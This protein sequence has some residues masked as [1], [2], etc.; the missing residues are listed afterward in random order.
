MRLDEL[1]RVN[2]D[3][4]NLL[5][6]TDIAT[7][8]L[9]RQLMIKSFTPAISEIFSLLPGDVGRPLADL[10][11]KIHCD[12]LIERMQTVQETLISSE[13]EVETESDS[14][15]QMRI[16]P[17]RSVDD[18]IEGVVA[19][20]SDIT[21]VRRAEQRAQWARLYA[22]SLVEAIPSPLVILGAH[23]EILSVN[24]AFQH[25]FGVAAEEAQGKQLWE[26]DSVP[27]RDS[28]LSEALHKMA[29]GEP[30]FDNLELEAEIPHLG[31]RHFALQG[32]GIERTRDGV[33]RVLVSL[34]DTTARIAAQEAT[35]RS[36]RLESLGLLAGGIAHDFNNLLMAITGNAG[37]A[38]Q[39]L[40]PDSPAT[41]YMR[42]IESAGDRAADLVT[43]M[44][45][46]AGQ[47]R[48]ELAV[49]DL[50]EVIEG[51]QSL[52]RSSLPSRA[53]VRYRLAADLPPVRADPGQ[54]GQICLNLLLNAKE[55]LPDEGGGIV[56]STG[57]VEADAQLFCSAY[58]QEDLSPGTYVFLEVADSGAG[59]AEATQAKMFDPFF[60][61]KF[62]GRG[63][64][65]A[66][67]LG[68]VRQHGGTLLVKSE[69]GSGTRVTMLLPETRGTLSSRRVD[70][71]ATTEMPP[72]ASG[73]GT[74][75]V[76]DDE[77]AVAKVT[78]SMLEG[79]G[80]GVETAGS[81]SSAETVLRDSEA[82]IDIVLLDLMMPDEDGV[83]TLE[84]LRRIR[85]DL[86][87]ILCSGFGREEVSRRLGDLPID[88]FLHKPYGLAAL[89]NT[90][91]GALR[92]R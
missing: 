8:F 7:I 66:A 53:R 38:R 28:G 76:V 22:E 57:V 55:A 1:A 39:E 92:G 67:V 88:G 59:M 81:G 79:A 71:R 90:V 16:L 43:Q 65:L 25:T 84:R 19:T 78:S 52:V 86:K 17:Y 54:I 31:H 72:V 77:Q 46:Y 15:Y 24:E 51:M 68:I 12:D 27:G 70:A 36:Q 61:T 91:M 20:F 18:V 40:K 64:G 34:T 87:V 58:L 47:Q 32:R 3:I 4:S 13:T 2:S 42:N 11:K 50:S 33:E 48:L 73:S 21:G 5:A 63:L 75:L 45:D 23:L 74:V 29:S 35:G 44:L 85:P 10:A 6:S 26:I 41:R 14:I 62:T 9:D 49:V 69:L 37:L 30:S 60:S 56:V 82:E 80:F 89:V 83:A